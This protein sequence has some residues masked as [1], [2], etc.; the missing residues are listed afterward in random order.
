MCTVSYIPLKNGYILTSNRDENPLR[1]TRS[2][3]Q[4]QLTNGETII[5]P[6]DKQKLGT[7]I[8]TNTRNKTACLLNGAYKKH[9]RALPYKRSRGHYVVE[10]FMYSTFSGFAEKADLYN[11]EPFTLIFIEDADLQLLVWDGKEKHYSIL[12][13]SLPQM[14]SSATLYS[15]EEHRKKEIFFKNII[16]GDEVGETQI[17]AAHGLEEKTPFIL[18]KP[19]V[20]TVSIAQIIS[21]NNEIALHYYPKTNYYE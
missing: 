18:D 12:D 19:H 21:K 8:A 3:K 9:Q 11:I 2:P 7:W 17:L 1:D 13:K 14:W 6:I 10:A 5:A 4:Q 15:K 20:K 16:D